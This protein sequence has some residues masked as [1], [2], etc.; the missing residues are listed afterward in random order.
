[1][2]PFL[3]FNLKYLLKSSYMDTV[4]LLYNI[5]FLLYNIVNKKCKKIIKDLIMTL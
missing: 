3:I 5:N 4:I 2:L 1:M